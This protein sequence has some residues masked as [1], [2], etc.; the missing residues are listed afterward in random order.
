M[1]VL[2]NQGS[3]WISSVSS[4]W[5]ASEMRK[6]PV[7][8]KS[9]ACWPSWCCRERLRT[10]STGPWDQCRDERRPREAASVTGSCVA[11]AALARASERESWTVD[12]LRCCK[13]WRPSQWWILGRED[14][15]WEPK[16][17]SSTESSSLQAV[18]PVRWSSCNRSRGQVWRLRCFR[19]RCSWWTWCWTYGEKP[20][21]GIINAW[22]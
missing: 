6:L 4:A 13:S 7:Q 5:L 17:S 21:W 3:C 15:A 10:R 11:D 1:A 9:C 14:A 19:R 16:Q 2:L 8:P 20:W 12:R 22:Q 18:G